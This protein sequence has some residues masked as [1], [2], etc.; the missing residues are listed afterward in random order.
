MNE[1]NGAL[2]DDAWSRM[3]AGGGGELETIGRTKRR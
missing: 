2:G 3:Q 1:R